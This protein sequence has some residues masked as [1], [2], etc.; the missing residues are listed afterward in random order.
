MAYKVLASTQFGY[1]EQRYAGLLHEAFVSYNGTL[2]PEGNITVYGEGTITNNTITGELGLILDSTSE[3]YPY[4]AQ[5]HR[6]RC[7][8]VVN[9]DGWNDKEE[10]PV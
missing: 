6:D 10:E 3:Y 8:D 9:G 7:V 4:I 5:I 1:T 2:T